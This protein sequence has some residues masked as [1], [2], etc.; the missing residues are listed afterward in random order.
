MD[1]RTAYEILKIRPGTGRDII[2]KKFYNFTKLYKIYQMGIATYLRSDEIEKMREAYVFL[3]YKNIKDEELIDLYPQENTGFFYQ[4][5]YKT[6]VPFLQ[7]HRAKVIYTIV[8]CFITYAVNWLINYH[9]IDIKIA[10]YGKQADSYYEE[11]VR[12]SILD[13]IEHELKESQTGIEN[14][15]MDYNQIFLSEDMKLLNIGFFP[16]PNV[17]VYV[18]EESIYKTLIEEGFDL[19]EMERDST[20]GV[21][22]NTETSLYK[23]ICN[24]YDDNRVWVAIISKESCKK[25]KALRFVNLIQENSKKSLN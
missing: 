7:R 20:L 8:M 19:I 11:T 10:I 3:C 14:P 9:P 6:I 1:D 2:F 4:I 21:Y 16:T 25:D 23:Y 15:R 17:D 22:V 18:M 13:G 5:Y 12:N 24:W